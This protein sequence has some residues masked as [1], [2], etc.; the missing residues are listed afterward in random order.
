VKR[1]LFLI[2]VL[3]LLACSNNRQEGFLQYARLQCSYQLK[4]REKDSLQKEVAAVETQLRGATTIYDDRMAVY[5][6]EV[7][8]IDGKMYALEIDYEKK[9][10]ALS[11]KHEATYRH[12]MTKAYRIG[13]DDLERWK[14][15]R[16]AG[17]KRELQS[18]SFQKEK[19]T[20]L[21][22]VGNHIKTLEKQVS[23]LRNRYQVIVAS[24]TDFQRQ[25]I[26]MEQMLQVLYKKLPKDEQSRF[27]KNL[28]R[29]KINPCSERSYLQG[30]KSS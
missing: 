23:D 7:A 20:V 13:I 6:N 5:E 9:Y 19:D 2:Y 28:Q 1:T 12:M 14:Q 16:I 21:L 15:S 22:K 24:A 29:I 3:L 10:V 4:I 26:G 8:V 27:N 30:V 17:F 11:D 25:I 18:V